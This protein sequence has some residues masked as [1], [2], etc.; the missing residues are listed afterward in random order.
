MVTGSYKRTPPSVANSQEPG[1]SVHSRIGLI[2]PVIWWFGWTF[3]SI[4]SDDNEDY[5]LR[6]LVTYE[7]VLDWYR[8]QYEDRR[9]W[10]KFRAVHN[11]EPITAVLPICSGDSFVETLSHIVVCLPIIEDHVAGIECDG[12]YDIKG[13]STPPPPPGTDDIKGPSTPPPPV[14]IYTRIH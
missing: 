12:T 14:S 10:H 1:F 7:Q 11:E 8:S 9:Q 5:M 3:L 13:P 2:V 4:M 6:D